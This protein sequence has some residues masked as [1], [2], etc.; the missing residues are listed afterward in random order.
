MN[1]GIGRIVVSFAIGMCNLAVVA[2][3]CFAVVGDDGL[4]V[5]WNE[6]IGVHLIVSGECDFAHWIANTE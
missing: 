3:H 2:A 4:D 1:A 5:N 6:S